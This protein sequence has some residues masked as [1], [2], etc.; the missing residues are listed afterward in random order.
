MVLRGYEQVENLA[1][2][3]EVVIC[4]DEKPN[5]QALERWPQ[6]PMRAG[7]IEK[8][9]FEYVRHGT[10]NFASALLVHD[11][12][13]VRCVVGVWTRTIANI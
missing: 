8:Q 11:G 10:V 5:M 6:H 9:E 2:R 4:F 12:M 1:Q 7:H 3:C 13:M